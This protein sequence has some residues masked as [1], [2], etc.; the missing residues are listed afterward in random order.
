MK[1]SI[2]ISLIL[3]TKISFA[4]QINIRV[5]EFKN[6]KGYCIACLFNSEKG[7]PTKPEIALKCSKLKIK[8]KIALFEFEK[9]PKGEYAIAVFHDENNNGKLDEN[10]L[11]MPKEGYGASNNKRS[12]FGPPKFD[13]SKFSLNGISSIN[14]YL[15]Y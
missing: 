7:F 4:Q 2:L 3:L 11:G 14:I 12:S 5:S 8:D 10:F 13:Q 1:I 15:K 6:D 9:L